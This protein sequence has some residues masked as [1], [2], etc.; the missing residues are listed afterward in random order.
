MFPSAIAS[1]LMR[2]ASMFPSAIASTLMRFAS[3]FTVLNLAALTTY[4]W[5]TPALQDILRATSL[6]I[7]IMVIPMWFS[8]RLEKIYG[9]LFDS[10]ISM[11]SM[12]K[13]MSPKYKSAI[14]GVGDILTHIVPVLILGIPHHAISIVI[15]YALLLLW[16]IV[17]KDRIG[18]IYVPSVDATRSLQVTTIVVVCLTVYRVVEMY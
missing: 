14:V 10:V 11:R 3:M 4:P 7:L 17:N 9:D 12:L 8:G 15:A 1:T 6:L 13:T 18:E 16:Y 5:L 2:F